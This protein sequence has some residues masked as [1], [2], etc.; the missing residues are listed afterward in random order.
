MTQ[1]ITQDMALIYVNHDDDDDSNQS[2]SNGSNSNPSTQFSQQI[3]KSDLWR[4]RVHCLHEKDATHYQLFSVAVRL[5]LKQAGLGS[6]EIEVIDWKNM[7]EEQFEEVLLQTFPLL[8]K[9]GG[10]DLMLLGQQNMFT[11]IPRPYN[12]TQLRHNMAGM[13]RKIFIRPVEHNIFDPN[14]AVAHM[15]SKLSGDGE[16]S[17]GAAGDSDSGSKTRFQHQ[18]EVKKLTFKNPGKFMEDFDPERSSREMRKMKRKIYCER[19]R[20]QTVYDD[21]GRLLLDR[22]DLCDCCERNCPGCHFPCSKCKSSK[23]GVECRTHR[24]YVYHAVDMEGTNKSFTFVQ[25]DMGR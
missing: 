12:P 20:K 7:N 10:F 19:P 9:A 4:V 5:Q 22:R 23:C 15:F 11:V 2:N 1:N 14:A 17:G 13:N 25:V 3:D 16:S 21:K 24:R 18:L 8:R 6:A